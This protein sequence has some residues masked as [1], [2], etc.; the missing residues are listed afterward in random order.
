VQ[1]N[2]ILS[3]ITH[4]THILN[5]SNNFVGYCFDTYRY[6]ISYLYLWSGFHSVHTC[7]T[8]T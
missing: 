2:I 7:H 4:M 1:P 5:Y 8:L 3:Y 6:N